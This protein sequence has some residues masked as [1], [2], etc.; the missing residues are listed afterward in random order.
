M[1]HEVIIDC[2]QSE[3]LLDSIVKRHGCHIKQEECEVDNYTPHWY[4]VF[5]VPVDE[6]GLLG[7]V[8]EKKAHLFSACKP[9]SKQS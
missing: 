5:Q 3:K 7:A 2:K 6:M 9:K 4:G 1:V 8:R